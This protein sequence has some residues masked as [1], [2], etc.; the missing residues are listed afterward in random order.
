MPRVPIFPRVP[1]NTINGKRGGLVCAGLPA[2]IIVRLVR[3][4][5]FRQSVSGQCCDFLDKVRHGLISEWI[6]ISQRTVIPSLEMCAE[7]IYNDIFVS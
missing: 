1:V 3:L 5:F 4:D 6:A 7:V 2:A